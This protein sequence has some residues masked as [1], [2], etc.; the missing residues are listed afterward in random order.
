M[1]SPL[2]IGLAVA[3]LLALLGSVYV[4]REDQTAMVLHLGKVVR[5]DVKPGL[6]FKVP[7]F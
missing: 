4:V 7:L 1:K 5:A 6:D 2:W 3:A